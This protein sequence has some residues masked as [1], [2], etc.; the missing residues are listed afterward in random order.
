MKKSKMIGKTIRIIYMDGEPAY[1]GRVGII[2]DVDRNGFTGT[3]G[4]CK[5]LP[6]VDDYVVLSPQ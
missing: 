6:Q 4:E 1:T 2:T 5:V 3:W